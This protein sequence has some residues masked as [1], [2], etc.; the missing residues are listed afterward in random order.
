MKKIPTIFDRDWEG[1]RGVIDKPIPECDWVF[2]DEGI[3]TEK[4]D[5]TNIKVRIKDG[6]ITDVWKRRNP[7]KEQRKLGVEPWY[8]IAEPSDSQ[9][10]HT[11]KSVEN[12]DTSALPDGE[13]PGEAYGGKIQGNP[14][15]VEPNIYFFT[16][17]PKTFEKFP[18]NYDDIKSL[19]IHLSSHVSPGHWAEG[20]VFHHADGRMAKIK[21]KDFKD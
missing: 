9:N 13:Y 8:E 4:V 10:K 7:N 12:A 21:R 16:V 14:L 20:V 19:V 1:N 15:E 3:A 18:R 2:K 17:N 11:F 6:K 5:G